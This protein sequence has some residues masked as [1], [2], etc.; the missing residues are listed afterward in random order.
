MPQIE[1]TMDEAYP[2]CMDILAA[3]L[4]PNLVSSP[5]IGKSAL[6]HQIS[7]KNLLSM[8]DVRLSQADPA[9]LNGFPFIMP[10]DKNTASTIQ[11]RIKAGYVPMETFPI[12]GDEIPEGKQGWL[13]MMDEFPSA[14]IS[15]QAAA[16]KIVL[17]KAVGMHRLHKNVAIIAAGNK[18]SDKAIVNRQ[19]TAMQSRLI[20]LMIRVCNTAWMNWANKNAIDYRVKSFIEFRPE[21]LHKFDPNHNDLTFPCPRTWEFMSKIVKPWKDI[22]MEKLAVLAGTVGDGAAREFFSYCKVFGRIPTIND[23]LADPEHCTLGDEPSIH[24]A[25]SG[26]VAHHMSEANA[27]QIMKFIPRLGIDFQVTILRAAVARERSI[28]KA[29]AVL[30]WL[31]KNS[32]ELIQGGM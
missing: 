25:L 32:D 14:P 31:A 10:H 21:L 26:L 30:K 3:G 22:Q 28:R 17:D 16:Y 15:V 7:D 23:I 13:I 1:V 9:D 11:K 8:I 5:G 29:P 19:G 24:Y 18:M 4:V 20:H 12:E 2:L 27:D 6:G